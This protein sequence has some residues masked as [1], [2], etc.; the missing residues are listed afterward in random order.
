MG[1][2]P[3]YAVTIEL[4]EMELAL[5]YHTVMDDRGERRQV[6][7]QVGEAP[8]PERHSV[9]THWLE[10]KVFGRIAEAE[11]ELAAA[12]EKAQHRLAVRPI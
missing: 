8:R 6:L 12:M 3:T 7:W 2:A 1:K 9:A 5:L 4:D 11:P 10:S